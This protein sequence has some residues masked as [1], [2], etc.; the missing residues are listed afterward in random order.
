[1][2]AE[3]RALHIAAHGHFNG[4]GQPAR[5]NTIVLKKHLMNPVD[6]SQMVPVYKIE[7][8]QA[9]SD[10][11]KDPFYRT[12]SAA[13]EANTGGS[14]PQDRTPTDGERLEKLYDSKDGS[15]TLEPLH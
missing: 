6:E 13:S 10:H 7:N 14:R 11:H 1:M 9:S 3:I 12:R 8:T 4:I 5:R 15:A 2:P